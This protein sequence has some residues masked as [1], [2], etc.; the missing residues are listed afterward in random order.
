MDIN[1]DYFNLCLE[2]IRIINYLNNNLDNKKFILSNEEFCY[3]FIV[4]ETNYDKKYIDKKDM[5]VIESLIE[6]DDI[7][8]NKENLIKLLDLAVTRRVSNEF[9]K[10]NVYKC[11]NYYNNSHLNKLNIKNIDS[12]LDSMK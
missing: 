8:I 1:N 11:L 2:K 3:L 6:T 10:N 7:E 12:V 4:D 9:N 5:L